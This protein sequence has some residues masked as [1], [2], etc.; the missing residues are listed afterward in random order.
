MNGKTGSDVAARNISHAFA[1][2]LCA[3]AQLDRSA[4]MA[5]LSERLQNA[6]DNS[7]N[8]ARREGNSR[9][10]REGASRRWKRIVTLSEGREV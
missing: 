9:V 6:L 1:K 4:I 10:L 5:Y 8:R 3:R 2:R 7:A